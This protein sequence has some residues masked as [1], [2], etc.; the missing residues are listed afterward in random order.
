MKRVLSIYGNLPD[1]KLDLPDYLKGKKFIISLV[2]MAI[3]R[4]TFSTEAIDE[5]KQLLGEGCLL[6]QRGYSGRC[7]YAHNETDPWHENFCLYHRI[8]YESQLEL[9]VKGRRILRETFGANPILYAPLNHLY[10]ESTLAALQVLEY[11][12]LMDQN[13]FD[14]PP[15]R[16]LNFVVIPETR[17]SR[18]ARRSIG[19]HAH[20]DELRHHTVESFIRDNEFILPTD[21]EA[22]RAGK[23]ILKINEIGKR[24]GKLARDIKKVMKVQ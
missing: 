24:A 6:G 13:N 11:E 19:V 18:G 4:G 2:P 17:I 14:I 9:M 12:Y 5:V 8:S 1:R 3:E 23:M 20:V 10:D 22:K 15:Y 21:F 16:V 7:R